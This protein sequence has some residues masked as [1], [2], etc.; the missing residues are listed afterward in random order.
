[1]RI[2][3]SPKFLP[4]LA[5]LLKR[6]HLGIVA[7][8]ALLAC[9]SPAEGQ[10]AQE[11]RSTLFALEVESHQ[12]WL[13]GNVSALAELMAEEFHFVVMNGA[14]ETRAEVV[15]WPY[16]GEGPLRVR[17]LRVEPETFELRGNV[18]I[19]ISLLHLD[20]TARGQPVPPRMRILSIFTRDEGQTKW[21]LTARSI[22]PILPLR[23]EGAA[24]P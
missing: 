19:V 14:V 21:K 1:M 18:A 12:Q 11:I 13:E 4:I 2:S 15:A 22:T 6:R 5:S 7:T 23:P 3:P 20:A 16:T 9:F 10:S 17:S 24:R 8:G